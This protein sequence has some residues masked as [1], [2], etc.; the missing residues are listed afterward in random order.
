MIPIPVSLGFFEGPRIRIVK[1]DG[2]SDNIM[3]LSDALKELE[4]L[5]DQYLRERNQN[6]LVRK[7]LAAAF[8]PLKVLHT[9]TWPPD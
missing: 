8:A 3:S 2:T 7:K 5:Q 9:E 6:P 1:D 4:V